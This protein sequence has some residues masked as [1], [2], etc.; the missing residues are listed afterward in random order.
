M[1]VHTYFT[2]RACT[3]IATKIVLPISPYS[4]LVCST[5]ILV[6]S[7]GHLSGV[8]N[9]R[10]LG[11]LAADSTENRSIKPT[12]LLNSDATGIMR[13][14]SMTK[15]IHTYY[16]RSKVYLTFIPLS[17]QGLIKRTSRCQS[18]VHTIKYCAD[19]YSRKVLVGSLYRTY[20]PNR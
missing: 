19:R 11:K 2:F 14:F 8:G 13:M 6:R 20:R 1:L 12:P 9:R 18:W 16:P 15:S 7:E 10:K 5:S 4:S 3:H 17:G